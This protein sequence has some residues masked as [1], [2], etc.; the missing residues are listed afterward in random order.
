[1]LMRKQ[2]AQAS[3]QRRAACLACHPAH[4]ACLAH[5]ARLPAFPPAH[6]GLQASLWNFIQYN[7]VGGGDSA[8]YGVEGPAYYLRNGL[9]NF[10][11]LLPLALA[12]PALAAAAG[13]GGLGGGAPRLLLCVSPLY[14]WLAAITALPHK[15]ERFLYVAYPLVSGALC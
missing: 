5:S 15:E 10:Q 4:P 3:W 13:R 1:M 8:L 9:N 2:A 7:V 11:L 6:C 14:V 12:A